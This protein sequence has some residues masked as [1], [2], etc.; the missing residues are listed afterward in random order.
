MID[1][2]RRAFFEFG[3]IL[4]RPPVAQHS[5]TVKRASRVV[6]TVSDFV[7]D[8]GA[9]GPV[10]NRLVGRKIE[11]RRLQYGRRKHDFIERRA[12]VRV[13]RLRRYAPFAAVDRSA[14][15]VELALIFGESGTLEISIQIVGVDAER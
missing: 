15:P 13:Y 9:D 2:L 7:P 4:V 12:V 6:E 14:L 8:N 11:K 3:P 1:E 5:V 10:V